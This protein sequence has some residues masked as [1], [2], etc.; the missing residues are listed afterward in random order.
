MGPVII[1]RLINN[2]FI[3]Q[4]HSTITS[5]AILTTGGGPA[6]ME[7]KMIYNKAKSFTRNHTDLLSDTIHWNESGNHRTNKI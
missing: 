1:E 4:N 3:K 7:Y 2:G 6:S 5:R